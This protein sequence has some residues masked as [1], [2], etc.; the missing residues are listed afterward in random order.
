MFLKVLSWFRLD[1]SQ[2]KLS[3]RSCV[4]E[5]HWVH[6]KRVIPRVEVWILLAGLACT[7]WG[8]LTIVASGK[9]PVQPG[10]LA[11]VVL[12]DVLFVGAVL[13]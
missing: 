4:K 7:F 1:Q 6:I 11:L 8:K 10:Q 13:F 12:P 5:R 2:I 9:L 3:E